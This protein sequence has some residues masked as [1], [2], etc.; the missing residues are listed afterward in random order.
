M[1][2]TN[3]GPP[4]G[5]SQSRVLP[6]RSEMVTQFFDLRRSLISGDGPVTGFN[7][8]KVEAKR[9]AHADA[10]AAARRV[11]IPGGYTSAEPSE[12]PGAFIRSGVTKCEPCGVSSASRR[13]V[14]ICL[15][16]SVVGRLRRKAFIR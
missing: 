6:T 16:Q 5:S 13:P 8:R 10:E 4:K 14:S 15:L 11:T 9:K 1:Y 3:F 7:R 2:H 12:G